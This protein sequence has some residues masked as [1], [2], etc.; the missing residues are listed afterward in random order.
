[1]VVGCNLQGHRDGFSFGFTPMADPVQLSIPGS[2][3]EGQAMQMLWS[4]TV[5]TELKGRVPTALGVLKPE[6][7]QR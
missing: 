1:M 6:T 4:C 3:V 2:L 5:S 7:L